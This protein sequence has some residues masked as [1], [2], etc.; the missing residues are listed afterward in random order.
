MVTREH[1]AAV[2]TFERGGDLHRHARYIPNKMDPAGEYRR[3]GDALVYY[4]RNWVRYPFSGHYVVA[5]ASPNMG[6]WGHADPDPD[7]NP[8]WGWRARWEE[9]VRDRPEWRWELAWLAHFGGERVNVFGDWLPA[10]Q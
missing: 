8:G 7:H 4:W 9:A 2:S 1:I 6:E 3:E 5:I 10:R